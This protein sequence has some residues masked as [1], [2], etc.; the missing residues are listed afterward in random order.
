MNSEYKTKDFATAVCLRTLDIP[1]L[2]LEQG[3]GD[4]VRFVY[5]ID[6]I[7]A[8]GIVSRYWNHEIT[9]D[10]N[11]FMTNIHELKAR[12]HNQGGRT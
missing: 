10:A 4:F 2:R 6:P 8:E 1:L 12:L 9:V 5:Q 11:A 3:D 7:E